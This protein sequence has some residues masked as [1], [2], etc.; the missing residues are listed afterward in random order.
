MILSSRDVAA[1]SPG[2]YDNFTH[3]H[4]G[5]LSKTTFYLTKYEVLKRYAFET[6]AAETV[7]TQPLE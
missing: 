7:E 5:N 4:D 3:N 1:V 2:R 6:V